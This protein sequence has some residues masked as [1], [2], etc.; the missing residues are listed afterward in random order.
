MR[1]A[2]FRFGQVLLLIV[3]GLPGCGSSAGTEFARTR[4]Q[5]PSPGPDAGDAGGDGGETAVTLDEPEMA[6]PPEE[7]SVEVFD[8]PG[9]PEQ[10]APV[11]SVECDPL[12]E[13]PGCPAGTGCAP[14]VEYPNAAC[15]AEAYGTRCTTVGTGRQGDPCSSSRCAEGFLCVA[16]GR[17]TQCAQLCALPGANTCPAGLV[18]G[19]V[20]I[21][22]YGS[23][24]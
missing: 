1:D 14:F 6:R 7:E 16:T 20:D 2:R 10:P 21:E 18:C 5:A 3:A 11:R 19:N 8:D 22:G 12:A 17:G 15:A 24:F 13:V 23:C 9:C 4:E